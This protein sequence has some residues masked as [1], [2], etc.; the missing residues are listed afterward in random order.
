MTKLYRTAQGR[1]VD[2]ASIMMQN[3]QTRAVG[4]MKVN[5]R[6]DAVDSHNQVVNPRPNQVKRTLEQNIGQSVIT[7]SQ[8]Q[9]QAKAPVATPAAT[10]APVVDEPTVQPQGLAAAMARANQRKE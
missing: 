5:A 4:N 2:I 3:E 6:G 1:T 8:P 10:A 9:A 7:K